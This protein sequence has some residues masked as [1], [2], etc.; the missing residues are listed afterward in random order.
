MLILAG[1]T[2]LIRVNCGSA[3]SIDYTLDYLTTDNA[4]PPGIQALVATARGN[5]TS[6]GNT[7]VLAAPASNKFYNVKTMRFVNTHATQSTTFRVERFDGS[8][9]QQIAPYG[10][11]LLAGESLFVDE[12]GVPWYYSSGGILKSSTA[13]LDVCLYVASDVTNA[14]TSFADITGLTQALLS[15]HKYAFESHLYHQTNATTTGAQFGVNIGASPTLL[16]LAAIQQITS[17]VT[18]A[19]F[20][21]SAMVTAL[22]TAAVV[23]TTGPGANNFLAIVSGFIQPS[24]DGTFAMRLKSE[25]AVASGLIVKAGS[26]LK[27]RETNN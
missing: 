2:D 26:W 7:T 6:S 1:T 19:T 21:S 17:S 22:D 4:A 3:S 9:A 5:T 20:G 24:A 10:M 8:T 15:G 14:T 18:A 25:V 11:T 27:I 12:L 16:D 13:L 23:E